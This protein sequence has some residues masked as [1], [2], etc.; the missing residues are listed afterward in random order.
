MYSTRQRKR[1][2]VTLKRLHGL[3]DQQLGHGHLFEKNAT[4]N[5]PLLIGGETLMLQW[6][7]HGQ[8]IE[9]SFVISLPP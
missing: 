7:L 8:R 5:L 9:K 1:L 4:L 2:L 6:E 3:M